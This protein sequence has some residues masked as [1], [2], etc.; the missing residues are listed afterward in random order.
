MTVVQVLTVNLLTDG[1][2]AVALT[3]DPASE[4][5]R[6]SGP[7]GHGTLFPRRLQLALAL[8][9]IAVG[10]TATA[11]YVIGRATEPAA[12]QTMAF[13][14]LACAELVLVF[15]IRSGTS[16]AWR[17]PHNPLLLTSVLVS[18]VLLM[19]SIYLA[20]LRDAFGTEPLGVAAA[21][22]VAGLAVAPSA[23]TETVKAVLRGRRGQS[24]SGVTE[25]EM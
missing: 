6:R 18:F 16:A 2:P 5:T 7:R 10:L 23:L 4:Q 17:A 11:A 8:M 21:V 9:G 25:E 14:T 13:A 24:A 12:A 22:M 15:S 19:L 1:L 3:R 20:P